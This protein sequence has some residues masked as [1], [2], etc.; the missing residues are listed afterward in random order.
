MKI[1]IQFLCLLTAASA[2]ASSGAAPATAGSTATAP[3]RDPNVIVQEELA[4]PSLS[5]L[6]AYDA[7]RSLRPRFL[8]TRGTQNFAAAGIAGS[9][10]ESGLPHASIDGVGV[11]ALDELKNLSVRSVIEIRFLDAAAAMQR[12]GASARSGPV[13]VVRTM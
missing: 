7:I 13:I 6:N 12:F 3:R 1:S 8:S 9:D 2:C 5:T 10:P 11:V 4:D